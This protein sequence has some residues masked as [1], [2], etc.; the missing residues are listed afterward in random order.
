MFVDSFRSAVGGLPRIFWV[1][2][3][4]T[5]INRLGSFVAPFLTLYLTERQHLS[6]GEAGGIVSLYGLGAFAAAPTGGFLSD[7]VGRKATLLFGLVFTS[8]GMLALGFATTPWVV[9]VCALALGFFGELFRPAVSA[10]VADVVPAGDRVRAYA[11]IYWAANVGFAVAPVIAGYMANRNFL[12]LFVVN[13]VASLAYA[14]LVFLRIPETRPSSTD[15]EAAPAPASPAANRNV[16]S[17]FG[18]AWSGLGFGEIAR[19]TVFLSFVAL[20]FLLAFL[21]LQFNSTLP[22]DM[23]AHGLGPSDFGLLIAINGVLIVL[24]QPFATRVLGRFRRG[25]VMALSGLLA[26]LGFGLNAVAG[27]APLY[28]VAIVVWTLGEILQS[29]VA[30]AIVADLAPPHARGRYQGVFF[31]S[32]GL[33]SFAAPVT[34]GWVMERFGATTLW[35]F[36]FAVGALIA[37]GH[38]FV[39]GARRRRLE[40]RALTTGFSLAGRD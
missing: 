2:W 8:A 10:I 31:M 12:V 4:G 40:E 20:S 14:I 3:V 24:L 7:R 29:P 27:T 39:A 16:W 37:V 26:G 22:L 6:P 18:R 35:S 11:L 21:F 36:C 38:L 15:A 13:A 28:A 9:A 33:A 5:L 34:G 17:Y 1:L 19:D 32:W 23:R 30:S 25:N